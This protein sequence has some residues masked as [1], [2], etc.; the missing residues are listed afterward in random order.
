MTTTLPTR[1][2]LL[3]NELPRL[4]DMSGALA[5]RMLL[6]PLTQNWYGREDLTLLDRLC[7]ELPG[8][9]LWA[10]RGWQRL[11]DQGRFT[12]PPAADALRPPNWTT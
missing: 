4:T 9:L 7:C 6:L 3:T 1:L 10:I 11:R 12:Q 8:I 2:I 5:G